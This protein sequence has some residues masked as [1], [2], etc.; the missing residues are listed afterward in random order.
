MF[1]LD[2]GKFQSRIGIPSHIFGTDFETTSVIELRKGIG[3][4]LKPRGR[5][6]EKYE[7]RAMNL[8]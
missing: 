7:A 1:L 5:T 6:N 8:L 4:V 2:E 3:Y